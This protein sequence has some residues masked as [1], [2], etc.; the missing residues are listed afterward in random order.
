MKCSDCD[1]VYSA[2]QR[3]KYNEHLR[4]HALGTKEPL[5]TLGSEASTEIQ[6]ILDT[7]PI[8]EC[9]NKQKLTKVKY[10]NELQCE[11]GT[12]KLS[13]KG[14]QNET[15]QQ[16]YATRESSIGRRSSPPVGRKVGKTD[17]RSFITS[18]SCCFQN[19]NQSHKCIPN[20]F[21]FLRCIGV[22]GFVE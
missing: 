8:N 22:V 1:F 19:T 9:L 2:D 18:K 10:S 3:D 11:R 7:S 6:Q 16:K 5:S 13:V 17:V 4:L 20:F 12:S 14:C 21:S 15:I